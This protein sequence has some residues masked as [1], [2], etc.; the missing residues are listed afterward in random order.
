M[1]AAKYALP[2]HPPLPPSPRKGLMTFEMHAKPQQF[3]PANINLL[4]C[5]VFNFSVVS[6]RRI[7]SNEAIIT[8]PPSSECQKRKREEKKKRKKKARKKAGEKTTRLLRFS[9]SSANKP[10]DQERERERERE[11]KALPYLY[12]HPCLQRG[13]G[14][15]DSPTRFSHVRPASAVECV[16]GA[17]VGSAVQSQR[18]VTKRLHARSVTARRLG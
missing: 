6:T 15:V 13:A 1:F 16:S 4:C 17:G 8:L 12:L 11:R 7:M 9:C 18:G 3:G 5:A 14:I 10:D 2:P